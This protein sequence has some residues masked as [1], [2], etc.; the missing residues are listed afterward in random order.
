MKKLL[1]ILFL[2]LSGCATTQPI[3]PVVIPKKII[4]P[5]NI[6]QDCQV[7][8][9]PQVG[10]FEDFMTTLLEDKKIYDLCKLQNKSKKDFIQNYEN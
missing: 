9:K 2:L 10:T 5:I 1:L 4:A 6:M 3:T 7:F 8:K